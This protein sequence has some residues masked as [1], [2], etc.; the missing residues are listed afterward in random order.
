MRKPDF[1]MKGLV[2]RLWNVA[3]IKQALLNHAKK[4]KEY[5]LRWSPECDLRNERYHHSFAVQALQY[6]SLHMSIMQIIKRMK[7]PHYNRAIA[8]RII[9]ETR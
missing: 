8:F 7:V 1:I 5:R 3:N 6:S 4:Q 9:M 2:N